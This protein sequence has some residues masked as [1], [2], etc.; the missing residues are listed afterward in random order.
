MSK[1]VYAL[2]SSYRRWEPMLGEKGLLFTGL[3]YLSKTP[4][5]PCDKFLDYEKISVVALT[6]Q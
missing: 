3:L 1:R 6:T 2:N 5:G 4:G